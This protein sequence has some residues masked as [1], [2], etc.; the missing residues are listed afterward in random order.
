MPPQKAQREKS[1]VHFSDI[2]KQM[3]ERLSVAV[4][5]EELV[6]TIKSILDTIKKMETRVTDSVAQN[7]ATS[8]TRFNSVQNDLLQVEQRVLA[9]IEDTRLSG[10]MSLGEAVQQLREEVK[11]VQALIPS[12]PDYSQE[13]ADIRAQI[14]VLP[15]EKVGEDYRNALEALPEG[16]KLA[17]EAIEGLRKELNDL[18]RVR[19]TGPTGGIIGRDLIK[20]YDLSP[21]LDGVTKT[22]NIPSVWNII[23][24]DCSSFPHALRKN[25]D[26]TYTSQTITFTSE[27]DESTTLAAGQTVVLT[28]V[29]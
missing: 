19:A 16:D 8:D 1:T 27:I 2:F 4:T 17:I 20:D 29:S 25:I 9:L 3:G 28:I 7:K 10:S 11:S 21:Y 5:Q 6:H 22:F 26:F 12:L 13:F 23:S 14:P 24:V 15:V 18:K